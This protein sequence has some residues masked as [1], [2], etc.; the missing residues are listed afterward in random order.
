M[1]TKAEPGAICGRCQE[2]R[3]KE[4]G[5]HLKAGKVKEMNSHIEPPK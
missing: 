3:D 2:Q 1:D 4:C 5:Q